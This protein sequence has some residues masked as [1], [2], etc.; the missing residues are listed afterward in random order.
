MPVKDRRKSTSANFSRLLALR[1][2]LER[3]DANE[4]IQEVASIMATTLVISSIKVFCD[5]SLI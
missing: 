4:N 5:L 3:M 2:R 1:S